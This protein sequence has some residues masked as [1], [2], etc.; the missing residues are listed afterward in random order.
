M[1]NALP[2]TLPEK[3][4][5]ELSPAPTPPPRAVKPSPSTPQETPAASKPGEPLP[6]PEPPATPEPTTGPDAKALTRTVRQVVCRLTGYPEEMIGLDLDME[7]D[8]GIDSIKRVEILSALEE[9]C[10][11]LPQVPPEEMGRLR[12]L[13]QIIQ[14]L[15]SC[16]QT[17]DTAP[18][19]PP[20]SPSSPPMPEK[21]G[22]GPIHEQ[23]LQVVSR[24]TGYP[25]E[26]LD[27]GMDMESDLGIDSI[28]RVEILSAMEEALPELPQIPP[29][30][31]GSLR[32]LDQIA[33]FLNGADSQGQ[34]AP[35]EAGGKTE[36]TAMP[37]PDAP[38]PADSLNTDRVPRQ[39]VIP[40]SRP[41]SGKKEIPADNNRKVFLAPATRT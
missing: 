4:K 30:M 6:A 16:G 33:A 31:M 9:S 3:P 7:S 27:G 21:P 1:G 13:G 10:P 17:T 32:T 37:A 8:L 14:Q 34:T 29:D 20:E 22:P 23:L 2:E 12:T 15:C 35:P 19:K 25:E 40:K 41:F 28:K 26:M 18:E 24:L 11:D 39:V 38:E 36:T 5:P